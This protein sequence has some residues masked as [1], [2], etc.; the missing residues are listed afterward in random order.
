MKKIIAGVI[1]LNL[2]ASCNNKKSN[3][4]PFAPITNL[5][6]SAVHRADSVKNK[7]KPE[8]PKPTEA[9]ESF[10]DFIYNF[11]SDDKFQHQRIV[12]PLPYYN[13]EVPS[14]IE[15]RYWKHDDLFTKQS[16]YTL[17]FDKEEDMDMVGDTALNSVQVEWIF[18]RTRMVKKYYFERAKGCWMLQAINLRPIAKSDD[19]RF[20]E[21]FARFAADSLFQCERI[22]QPLTFVTN[23]PD[24]DFSIVETTLELNQWFAFKPTLPVERLSNINYG[25]SNNDNSQTKI[26]ALKGVGNGFSNLLY[27]QRKGGKWELYKFEDTGI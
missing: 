13:G 26:L 15:E 6:D 5:V 22:R 27:F 20:V 9:D 19:E 3:I 24:D 17:L 2:L 21:F 1:I 18:M 4:D 8:E 16:Y 14:K 12:F 23:D 10:N 25:Q 7:N 11:A